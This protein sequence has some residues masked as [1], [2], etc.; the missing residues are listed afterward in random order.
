MILGFV[1]V[2]FLACFGEIR[3]VSSFLL[4]AFQMFWTA[5]LLAL[6]KFRR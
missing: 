1:L 4:F 5:L 2:A 3:Q 6:P